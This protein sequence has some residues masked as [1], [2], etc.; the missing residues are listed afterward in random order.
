MADFEGEM[1]NVKGPKRNAE[2]HPNIRP[3]SVVRC[4]Y[5]FD[6]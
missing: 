4:P 2:S 5:F 3:L 1:S 6:I